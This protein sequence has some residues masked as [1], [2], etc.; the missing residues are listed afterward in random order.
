MHPIHSDVGTTLDI[1]QEALQL[2]VVD[3]HIVEE[4][5][6]DGEDAVRTADGGASG[7]AALDDQQA[8]FAV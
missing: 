1:V 6:N 3:G 2:R 7:I 8:W 4:V 5:A